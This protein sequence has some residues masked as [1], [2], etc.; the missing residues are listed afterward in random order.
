[1]KNALKFIQALGIAVTG[2]GL[3]SGIVRNSMGDEYMYASIG[4]ALFFIAR[5]VETRMFTS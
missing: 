4:I 5:F 3:V 1:M 2:L